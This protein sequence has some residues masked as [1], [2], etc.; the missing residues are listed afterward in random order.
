M[1]TGKVPLSGN[2]IDGTTAVAAPGGQC[3]SQADILDV[4]V[5]CAGLFGI[6]AARELLDRCTGQS[7]LVL[8]A[9][10]ELDGIW[11][12]L[13]YPGIGSASDMYTFGNSFRPWTGVG[14]YAEVANNGAYLW[15]TPHEADMANHP[16]RY[17]HSMN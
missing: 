7:F 16:T 8:E 5:V 4:L 2:K 6:G 11:E 1:Q 3:H 15:A 17:Q 13:R 9:R 14:T 12:E 10:A